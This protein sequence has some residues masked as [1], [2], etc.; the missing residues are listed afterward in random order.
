MA[1]IQML[2]DE[3]C[4]LGQEAFAAGLKDE[5]FWYRLDCLELKAQD[6][7]WMELDYQ[8]LQHRVERFLFFGDPLE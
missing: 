8:A 6:L 7:A 4:C 5:S 2:R 3:V 1:E